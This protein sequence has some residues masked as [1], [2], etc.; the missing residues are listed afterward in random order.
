MIGF[1]P[2]ET[3]QLLIETGGI[4]RANTLLVAACD[5]YSRRPKPMPTERRQFEALAQRL[6]PTASQT[7]RARAAAKLARSPHLSPILENLVV[8]NIGDELASFLENN[9]ELKA[10]LIKK[11]N[12]SISILWAQYKAE[13][14]D[15][16][17]VSVSDSEL[18]HFLVLKEGE[19]EIGW[20]R[21]NTNNILIVV[22]PDS[23]DG[24]RL[25]IIDP[26]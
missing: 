9:E 12:L 23:L 20:L 22:D 24:F 11:Y 17:E 3:F 2:Y 5:A 26:E 14:Y 18:K 1:Q 10:Q 4:D 21:I 16:N 13:P 6:F 25:V 15:T 7:A 8:E 19:G